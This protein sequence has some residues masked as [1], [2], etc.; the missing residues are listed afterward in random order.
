M[1]QMYERVLV[2]L[3]TGDAS[4]GLGTSGGGISP[5]ILTSVTGGTLS[6]SSSES[7][8]WIIMT[9]FLFNVEES[10]GTGGVGLGR[11]GQRNTKVMLAHLGGK[12][13][14]YITKGKL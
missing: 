2:V 9:C 11:M 5:A 12:Q 8:S 3:S 10:M 14:V 4:G 13:R 7:V 1:V 6:L